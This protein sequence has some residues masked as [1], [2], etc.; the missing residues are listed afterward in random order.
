MG[1]RNPAFCCRRFFFIA[2]H[3]D[4][5]SLSLHVP[6]QVASAGVPTRQG[7]R[8]HH[9]M[10]GRARFC[11]P[12]A[13]ALAPTVC[14]TTR[15]PCGGH[16]HQVAARI[17]ISLP[18][19]GRRARGEGTNKVSVR[20]GMGYAG[21]LPTALRAHRVPFTVSSRW[22]IVRGRRIMPTRGGSANSVLPPRSLRG[23]VRS[24]VRG[25]RGARSSQHRALGK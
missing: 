15:S 14:S 18:M 8:G 13:V 24:A 2:R 6:L 23:L 11:W 25:E 4:D 22:R 9:M 12:R 16:E 1:K 5:F 10:H 19:P 17:Q 20:Q 3:N 7:G 21:A